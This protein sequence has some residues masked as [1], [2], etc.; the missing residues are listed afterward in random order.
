MQAI[1]Q[2][3]RLEE[4]VSARYKEKACGLHF[5]YTTA[6]TACRAFIFCKTTTT[7]KRRMERSYLRNYL[8]WVHFSTLVVSEVSLLTLMVSLIDRLHFNCS[9]LQNSW[10][11][12]QIVS[13]ALSLSVS[14]S[15]PPPP[16]ASHKH[17][18]PP[19]T[20]PASPTLSHPR[21]L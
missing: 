7:T 19:H 5:L 1:L 21:P 18:P 17:P 11:T 12:K 16:F 3:V 13:A 9:H 14:L 4:H 2:S 10:K 6:F 15:P 8:W 20:H